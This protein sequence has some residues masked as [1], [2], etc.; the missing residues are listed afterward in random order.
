MCNVSFG[1]QLGDSQSAFP[2]DS[3]T[4]KP[5]FSLNDDSF[6]H[7]P[8]PDMGGT[9]NN[10]NNPMA[11]GKNSRASFASLGGETE[12]PAAPQQQT[13][14]Q[15]ETPP[16]SPPPNTV[17][18]DAKSTDTTPKTQAIDGPTT[19]S[20]TATQRL[21]NAINAARRANGLK[22]LVLDS[23]LSDASR[24]NNEV[25]L[26]S[27][28]LGHHNGLINGSGGEITYGG[29]STTDADAQAAVDAWLSS[30]GHRSIMLGTE[31]TK[32]G[33]DITNGYA[34]ANFS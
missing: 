14:H 5:N 1:Q 17:T 11:F 33:A 20:S 19:S 34:T 13:E 18:M 12:K 7:A 31:Y 22:D 24:K 21:L 27:G 23:G 26:S 4:D 25:S 32:F 3:S 2:M 28:V 8:P 16:T 15:A 9:G 10:F 29:P 6:N 30:P